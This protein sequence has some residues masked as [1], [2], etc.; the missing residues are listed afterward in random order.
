MLLLF[1]LFSLSVFAQSYELETIVYSDKIQNQ[2][3]DSNQDIKIIEKENFK[4]E[5]TIEDV[6]RNIPGVNIKR[7]SGVSSFRYRG[8]PSRYSLILVNGR[9]VYDSAG[10][11]EGFNLD[12]IDISIIDRVEIINGT[13]ALAYGTGSY[14][15][16]INLITENY[17][18][19]IELQV[20][21]RQRL[22]SNLAR[23]D[24]DTLL[25][26]RVFL[27][28]DDSLSAYDGG[29]EKD[30]VHKRGLSIGY[31]K[32]LS[33]GLGFKIDAYGIDADRDIDG[34]RDTVFQDLESIYTSKDIANV[35][36]QIRRDNIR[37]SSSF[38]ALERSTTDYQSNQITTN[39]FSS[40]NYVNNIEWKQDKIV[41]GI[42]NDYQLAN[43]KNRYSRSINS[44]YALKD[45]G[46]TDTFSLSMS[47][48]LESLK[49]KVDL[50]YA[51]GLTSRWGRHHRLS[52]NYATGFK[53]A[54]FFQL[55]DS[56]SGNSDLKNERTEIF[57]L[58]Y[59]YKAF[60]RLNLFHN[61]INNQI[62]YL[63]SAQRYQNT[64]TASSKG[65]E[66]RVLKSLKKFKFELGSTLF[67]TDQ[68]EARKGYFASS[69]YSIKNWNVYSR[70]NYVDKRTELGDKI[71]GYS[72]LYLGVQKEIK[73]FKISFSVFNAFNE[74]YQET[75]NYETLGRNYELRST[76]TF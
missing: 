33:E 56:F 12:S 6:L 55:N 51:A 46:L 71:P 11:D 8:L 69:N 17:N 42:E 10:I 21:P 1:T 73:K 35:S 62:N 59:Q 45:F 25:Y 68:D 65:I 32:E 67:D 19:D 24:R 36:V 34:V 5:K 22:N 60:F 4:N 23:I 50:S 75:L 72:L 43:I 27:E 20:G 2:L 28:R 7:S 31:E 61:Q 14:A 54:T 74:N 53:R 49:D 30:E 3:F 15:S 63:L 38:Y 57:D 40:K 48:R 44:V 26:S 76:Y 47:T 16:V 58:S 13:S 66:V 70:Y 52:L 18:T 64:G 39:G 41:L 37:F 29:N 9:R